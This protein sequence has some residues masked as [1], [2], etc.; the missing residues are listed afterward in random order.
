MKSTWKT[1]ESLETGRNI[2]GTLKGQDLFPCNVT[3]KHM[4]P[5]CNHQPQA[6]YVPNV[7][8]NF[9][10]I[11]PH[12][13]TITTFQSQLNVPTGNRLGTF[14]M[15]L[16]FPSL[17]TLDSQVDHITNVS[18]STMWVPSCAHLGCTLCVSA[19]FPAV[20]L[21]RYMSTQS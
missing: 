16:I 14:Y 12:Q 6:N 1:L 2:S 8:L 18:P 10:Q 17:N 19:M 4:F 9:P 5:A 11:I 13:Q 21:C 15:F 3:A 20:Y 7:P